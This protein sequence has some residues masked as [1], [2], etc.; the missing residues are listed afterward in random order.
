MCG[1]R[2]SPTAIMFMRRPGEKKKKLL[3]PNLK[4]EIY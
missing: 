2:L 3:I 4:L 1:V